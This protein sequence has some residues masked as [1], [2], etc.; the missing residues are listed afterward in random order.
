V[1]EHLLSI[2]RP[3][4]QFPSLRKKGRDKG[5]EGGRERRERDRER[6]RR[7]EGIKTILMPTNFQTYLKQINTK[8]DVIY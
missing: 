2:W 4:V 5:R 7:K 1:V 3:W 6:E 8:N